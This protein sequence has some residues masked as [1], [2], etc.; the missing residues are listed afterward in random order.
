MSASATTR[1][2]V[3]LVG[4]CCLLTAPAGALTVSEIT[5]LSDIPS[6]MG[7]LPSLSTATVQTLASSPAVSIGILTDAPA[8]NALGVSAPGV[9]LSTGDALNLNDINS[10]TALSTGYGTFAATSSPNGALLSSFAPSPGIWADLS[11]FKL[12]FTLPEA[13]AL[14]FDVALVTDEAFGTQPVS[15]SLR[16]AFGVFLLDGATPNLATAGGEFISSAHPDVTSLGGG[17]NRG[18]LTNRSV[19]PFLVPGGTHTLRFVIADGTTPN[20]DTTVVLSNLR[21]A[22][23]PGVIPEPLT[24]M[25]LI[26]G[27]AAAAGYIRRRR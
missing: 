6:S 19:D 3:L 15:P 7:S 27:C 4:L 1:R 13:S 11:F 9:V 10:G 24:A 20:I 22:A 23:T 5:A 8:G 16:D 17:L 21:V 14:S 18:I 26:G 12:Q 25:A 2:T